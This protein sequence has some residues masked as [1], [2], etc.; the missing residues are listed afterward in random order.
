MENFIFCAVMQPDLP[1]LFDDIFEE[2]T[3]RFQSVW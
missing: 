3:V 2:E 1:D